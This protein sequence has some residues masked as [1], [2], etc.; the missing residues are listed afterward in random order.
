MCATANQDRY[1]GQ[2]QDDCKH[3]DGTFFYIAK[4]MHVSASYPAGLTM[5]TTCR[6][7]A[8]RV[9]GRTALPSVVSFLLLM[10][11]LPLEL[12]CLRS[13]SRMWLA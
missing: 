9:P 3:G 5:L 8:T 11:L 1:E 12:A 6:T 13:N 10:K 7:S 4:V 2:W